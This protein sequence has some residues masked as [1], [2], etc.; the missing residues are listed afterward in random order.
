MICSSRKALSSA[1]LEEDVL[2]LVSSTYFFQLGVLIKRTKKSSQ[3]P[4]TSL[5]IRG[6]A[7]TPL[8]FAMIG[9]VIPCSLI[10]GT[11]G[12]TVRRFSVSAAI[13]RTPGGNVL[14]H[15]LWLWNDDLHVS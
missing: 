7:S 15:V 14:V 13:G 12:K 6:G 8:A 5:A 10:V 11:L 1:P 9:T 4:T 2:N 3:Y